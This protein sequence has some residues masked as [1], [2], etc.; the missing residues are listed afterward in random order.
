MKRKLL[1]I[2]SL[3][4]MLLTCVPAFIANASGPLT[5]GASFYSC[6]EWMNS[7]L[8]TG[9]LVWQNEEL[10]G[11]DIPLCIKVKNEFTNNIS[12]EYILNGSTR[13][14]TKYNVYGKPSD[15]PG[16]TYVKD[17][18]GANQPRYLGFAESGDPF[19]NVNF[20]EDAS[21]N[22]DVGTRAWY[23]DMPWTYSKDINNSY[24]PSQNG[25]FD[26][27]PQQVLEKDLKGI[28]D[29]YSGGV[30]PGNFTKLGSDWNTKLFG[31]AV[32]SQM[33]KDRNPGLVTMWHKGGTK[34]WYDSFLVNPTSGP[35]PTMD[36]AINPKYAIINTIDDEQFMELEIFSN[37]EDNISNVPIYYRWSPN[38][39]SSGTWDMKSLS[40]TIPSIMGRTEGF[41]NGKRYYQP[42]DEVKKL[43]V[44][45]YYVKTRVLVP[46]VILPDDPVPQTE[47]VE[48]VPMGKCITVTDYDDIV[49]NA[50]SK[51][52]SAK[53]A[54]DVMEN[55]SNML[56]KNPPAL[57]LL[58]AAAGGVDATAQA[59]MDESAKQYAQS[60]GWATFKT[61]SMW[62]VAN[63]N[64][65]KDAP[66]DE[67][68]YGNNRAIWAAAAITGIPGIPKIPIETPP[69]KFKSITTNEAIAYW[70]DIKR[71]DL[72]KYV[73]KC[74]PSFNINYSGTLTEHNLSGL[75]PS[76]VY[77]CTLE[78]F[79]KA[80]ESGG[81]KKGS[82]TTLALAGPLGNGFWDDKGLIRQI[83]SQKQSVNS[84]PKTAIDYSRYGADEVKS[85]ANKYSPYFGEK[86]GTYGDP[87]GRS[88]T[89]SWQFDYQRQ[90]W[91]SCKSTGTDANGNSYCIGG[92]ITV[93]D[94]AT[95]SCVVDFVAVGPENWNSI[96]SDPTGMTLRVT[97]DWNDDTTNLKVASATAKQCI[98]PDAR[99][100]G[101]NKFTY[102]V[103]TTY[104]SP[105]SAMLMDTGFDSSTNSIESDYQDLNVYIWADSYTLG[106]DGRT[107]NGTKTK[108]PIPFKQMWSIYTAL[109]AGN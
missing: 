41:I 74:S 7:G 72:G 25:Y 109:G 105:S 107:L 40:C 55:A 1:T 20:P 63:V 16:N 33:P 21:G 46:L 30:G 31:A 48:K 71:P 90:V 97:N 102:Y 51:I 70:D 34:D 10:A 43:G 42:S 6:D 37:Y 83:N 13:L 32:W 19:P 38:E 91:D 106:A 80:G 36:I 73:L 23:T 79:T 4:V 100:A 78:A 93:T 88:Q 12:K 24:K 44:S 108:T 50:S 87:A 52:S 92:W 35:M 53:T 2:I 28:I 94:T 104:V 57:E 64:P 49:Q 59:A 77:S 58:A 47:S 99:D 96:T 75:T 15:I 82:F 65:N 27:Y 81:I 9:L 76:T 84:I 14:D 8:N 95:N 60:M 29:K 101:R 89:Y 103:P 11:N 86:I 61:K 56:I 69:I 45:G 68:W 18:T 5:N 66:E 22:N 39:D 62:F 67:V 54:D 3:V 98:G 17:N 26:W 85:V